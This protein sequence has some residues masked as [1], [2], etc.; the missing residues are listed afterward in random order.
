MLLSDKDFHGFGNSREFLINQLGP[1]TV[2]A[3]TL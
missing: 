1:E 3:L 2:M